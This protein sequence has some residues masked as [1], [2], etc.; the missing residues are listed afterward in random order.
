MTGR[1]LAVA[2][3]AL[4]ALV[5]L[6]GCGGG[7]EEAATP[8]STTP[9]SATPTATR[10]AGPA[11]RALEALQE[12]VADLGA[13]EVRGQTSGSPEAG[14]RTGVADLRTGDFR[15]SVALGGGRRLEMIRQAD[16]TWTR[17][18]ASYWVELGYTA[19]SAA[20]ARGRWVVAPYDGAKQIADAVDP[21]SVV[22]SISDLDP[23]DATSVETVRRGSLRGNRVITF[24]RADSVQ[25]L[26]L[27]P[28]ARPRL[29]RVASTRA[30][31]TTTVDVTELPGPL[32]LRLPDAADVVQ[33]R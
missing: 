22:R 6:A 18:P 32:R 15:A 16:L 3:G 17:A 12:S 5:L 25:R 10:A 23:S 2:T 4:L 19:A 26:F 28:D 31:T 29:L 1:S 8:P 24:A 27:T 33:P 11:A 14:R 21:G 20:R 30:G 7:Q 9:P 13:V